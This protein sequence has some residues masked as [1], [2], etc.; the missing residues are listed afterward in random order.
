MLVLLVGG[1]VMLPLCRF[2]ASSQSCSRCPLFID[3]LKWFLLPDSLHCVD[4]CF[5]F[6]LAVGAQVR[7]SSRRSLVA[8]VTHRLINTR[9]TPSHC[10]LLSCPCFD[11]LCNKMHSFI[12]TFSNHGLFRY[13]FCSFG[14]SL[15]LS[16]KHLPR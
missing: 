10:L 7:G 16:A 3:L 6:V 15:I 4:F 2:A 13:L 1:C 12:C 14:F 5:V 9:V 11:C 8:I